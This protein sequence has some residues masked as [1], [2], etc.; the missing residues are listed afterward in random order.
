M[1]ELSLVSKYGSHS[2]L[3]LQ[4]K[5]L[6]KLGVKSAEIGS[7]S[8]LCSLAR[9]KERSVLLALCGGVKVPL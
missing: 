5:I 7:C 2:S 1:N 3:F 8:A 4:I 9:K 6:Q